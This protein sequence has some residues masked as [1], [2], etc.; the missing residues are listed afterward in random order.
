MKPLLKYLAIVIGFLTASIS[1]G[2]NPN[3]PKGIVYQISLN[4]NDL[5]KSQAVIT[6]YHYLT[7]IINNNVSTYIF[8]KYQRFSEVDSI[9]N[10]LTKA[11]CNS[12]ILAYK[13]QNEIPLAEA[14][15]MQYKNDM[16]TEEASTQRKGSKKITVK[17]VNYLLDVQKSGLKHYYALA[18]PVNSIETVDKLLEQIDNEQIIE[19][20]TSDDIYSI[21]HYEKFEDVLNARKHFIDGDINDVFIMAQITDER[22]EVDETDNFAITIQNLVNDLANN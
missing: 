12:T 2:F 17:E 15:S 8:G 4:G 5:Q 3:L 18:I 19:I 7:H 10:L 6:E 1:N 9:Q 13:N 20:S 11:G 16:L 14:I 21:G 22:I